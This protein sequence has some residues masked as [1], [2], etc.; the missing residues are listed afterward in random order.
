MN[1]SAQQE[2][3]DV[4]KRIQMLMGGKSAGGTSRVDKDDKLNVK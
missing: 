1:S 2:L 4:K 3:I